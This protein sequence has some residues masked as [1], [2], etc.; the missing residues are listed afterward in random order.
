MPALV[1]A[2]AAA[3]FGADTGV[4][5]GFGA[6]GMAVTGLVWMGGAGRLDR[7]KIGS[8]RIGRLRRR[9]GFD[10]SLSLD[11][12][13]PRRAQPRCRG[14]FPTDRRR[15][16]DRALLQQQLRSVLVTHHAQQVFGY[17]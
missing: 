12:V 4:A 16:V 13:K 1:L 17:G 5:A 14:V 9:R 10:W 7:K 15:K 3:G 11:L 6:S 8:R 2:G